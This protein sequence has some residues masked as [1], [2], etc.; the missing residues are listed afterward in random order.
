MQ[1]PC[2]GYSLCK[3]LS[4][5]AKIK[6]SKNM[7]KTILQ[8]YYSCSVEKA[9]PKNTKYSRHATILKIGHLAKTIAH[10]ET[11]AFAKWWVWVKN[12]KCQKHAKNHSTMTLQ[13]FCAKIRS[14]KSQI[15][16]KWDNFEKALFS[17]GK[18]YNLCKMFSFGQKLKMPETCEK[19]FYKN[20]KV[21]LYKKPL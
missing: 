20:I 17:A 15:F 5:G 9:A 13:L 6:N 10:E 19:R 1:S 3:M 7:Q 4:F 21:V 16:K 12:Q 14:K 11:I 8:E 2:K 18:G